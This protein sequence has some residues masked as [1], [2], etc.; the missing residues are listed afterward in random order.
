[1]PIHALIHYIYHQF[2][3]NYSDKENKDVPIKLKVAAP[4]TCSHLTQ[5]DENKADN[6]EDSNQKQV[7]LDNLDSETAKLLNAI[8]AKKKRKNKQKAAKRKAR[9]NN[10]KAALAEAQT[11]AENKPEPDQTI[12]VFENDNDD[13]QG[14]SYMHPQP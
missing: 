12:A 6:D 9:K 11:A 2:I 14:T 13:N 5:N 3:V 8:A 10:K 7:E 4:L 1:M